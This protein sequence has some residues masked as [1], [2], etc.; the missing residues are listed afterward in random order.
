MRKKHLTQ[1]DW[2][3]WFIKYD[4]GNFNWKDFVQ[5]TGWNYD[6]A[7]AQLKEV[8]RR[9]R[10]KYRNYKK[11]GHNLFM[12]SKKKPTGRPSA[13]KKEIARQNFENKLPTLTREELEEIARQYYNEIEN[14]KKTHAIGSIA[15]L[16]FPA[17][18]IESIFSITRQS[19]AKYRR[20]YIVPNSR[21]SKYY[22]FHEQIK[23][24]FDTSFENYGRFKISIEL[25][26]LGIHIQP[27]TVGNIMNKHNIKCMV[28]SAKKPGEYK[29]KTDEFPDLVQRNF[30]PVEDNIVA[31]DVKYVRCKE[32]DGTYPFV[33]LSVAISHKTKAIE[34][35]KI[36]K[37]ND[38]ALVYDTLEKVKHREN[39]IIHSD[40]G[41]QYSHQMMVD[42]AKQ[43][44]YKISLKQTKD[45]LD[46]RE[47]EY[48]F[49]I[50]EV[51]LLQRHKTNRMN[52][53]N[54]HKLISD[55]IYW[56]NN[57][58]IQLRTNWNAPAEASAYISVNS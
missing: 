33:Y 19:V 8:R 45:P 29:I 5:K 51:E 53:Q 38:L 21:N 11:L 25:A 12:E 37:I 14:K 16:N 6:P 7:P 49:S 20:G 54:V 24:V 41:F 22:K 55:Y 18:R 52:F 58:R 56:Y 39:L 47:P 13:S 42:L 3:Y 31:T 28:R 32:S 30:N 50:L 40:R 43:K 46:N 9:F 26:K 48:F 44:N 36:S 17:S 15:K 57:K 1:E 2:I 10:N 27:R 23:D 34:S 4:E 35:F